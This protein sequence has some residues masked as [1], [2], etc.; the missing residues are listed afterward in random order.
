M[1]LFT[2]PFC[3]RICKNCSWNYSSLNNERNEWVKRDI[4]SSPLAQSSDREALFRS[5]AIIQNFK[6]RKQYSDLPSPTSCLK[7]IG[8]NNGL[9][10]RV[11]F[12]DERFHQQVSPQFSNSSSYYEPSQY[13]LLNESSSTI[14]KELC[15]SKRIWKKSAL[16]SPDEPFE[17]ALSF[18]RSP[19]IRKYVTKKLKN[20]VL[21]STRQPI[22][23]Q[24]IVAF[25]EI[26]AMSSP[27]HPFTESVLKQQLRR[28]STK[29]KSHRNLSS[30]SSLGT[31]VDEDLEQ[32]LNRMSLNSSVC[33][34]S[35]VN[36]EIS[37]KPRVMKP[38]DGFK[39]A[40]LKRMLIYPPE[41]Q[42]GSPLTLFK[43]WSNIDCQVRGSASK[44]FRYKVYYIQKFE[45]DKW[46]PN[47]KTGNPFR[48]KD[49][50]DCSTDY[51]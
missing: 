31:N 44:G 51:G 28:K 4:A 48:K 24:N 9:E 10:K 7:S 46:F 3:N 15:E 8:K 39:R 23:C 29:L 34:S 16:N 30:G 5:S 33:S 26:T 40:A 47:D 20:D 6:R 32:V 19:I 27:L 45:S 18:R 25:H 50:A 17:K 21:Q 43:T 22:K 11:N 36:I 1:T 12:Y 38:R 14:N 37:P 35:A 41:G 42:R 2:Y 49:D 13:N